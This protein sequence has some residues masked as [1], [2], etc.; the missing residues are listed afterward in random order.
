[1]NVSLDEMLKSG[2]FNATASRVLEIME[3]YIPVHTWFVALNN[4]KHNVIIKV[5]RKDGI[6]QEGASSPF[7]ETYCKL[8]TANGRFPTVIPDTEKDPL[9]SAL[10]ITSSLGSCSFVGLP[11]VYGETGESV[12][13]ICALDKEAHHYTKAEIEFL[14]TMADVLS[15]AITLEVTSKGRA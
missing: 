7:E 5:N 10:L 2:R 3:D 11:L 4:R 14:N 1:M 15:R 9:T 13:T 6:V 12:G 8:V